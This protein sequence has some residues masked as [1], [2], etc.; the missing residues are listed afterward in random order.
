MSWRDHLLEW[1]CALAV[2]VGTLVAMHQIER[3]AVVPQDM[4][5]PTEPVH[6]VPILGG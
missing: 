2:A 5:A 4:P 3:G 6:E 1:L